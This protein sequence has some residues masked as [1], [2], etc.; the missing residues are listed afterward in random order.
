MALPT[1]YLSLVQLLYCFVVVVFNV[2]LCLNCFL[3]FL[4]GE[5][6]GSFMVGDQVSKGRVLRNNKRREAAE[7][8]VRLQRCFLVMFWGFNKF[9]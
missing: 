9:G 6:G 5:G 4:G 2:F 1:H 8:H 7:R 3:L